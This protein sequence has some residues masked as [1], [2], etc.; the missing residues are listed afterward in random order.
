MGCTMLLT[1]TDSG[2]ATSV[3]TRPVA[4]AW[5]TV[6]RSMRDGER[7]SPSIT[8]SPIWASHATPSEKERVATRCGSSLLP[9][10][11]AAT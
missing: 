9:R 8:N 4:S 11:S 3:S 5:T 6:W 10:I 1:T 2:L 7:S